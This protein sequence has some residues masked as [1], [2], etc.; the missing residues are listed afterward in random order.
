MKWIIDDLIVS[1]VIFILDIDVNL[2]LLLRE[3]FGIGCKYLVIS[4]LGLV[5]L[6]EMLDSFKVCVIC[7]ILSFLIGVGV[8]SFLIIFGVM[9]VKI[10]WMIFF[11]I[12]GVVSVF[13]YFYKIEKYFCK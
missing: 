6:K 13:L 12:V 3:M 1:F 11:W 5:C 2:L 10:L 8:W 7:I 4:I 9:N